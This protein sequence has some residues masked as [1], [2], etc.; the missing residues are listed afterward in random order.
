M[1]LVNLLSSQLSGSVLKQLSQTIGAD[2]K[3]TEG[4]VSTALPLLVGALAR[5][6]SSQGEPNHCWARCP[7]I[8]TVV[9]ST[10]SRAS[11]AVQKEVPAT[12]SYAICCVTSAPRWRR[13]SATTAVWV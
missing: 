3:K 6:A 5:N 1:S 7:G 12:V 2:E 10:T 13:P 8:M 4:A 11:S 9:F